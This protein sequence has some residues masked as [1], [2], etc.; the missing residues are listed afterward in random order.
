MR[1]SACNIIC[2]FLASPLFVF[3]ILHEEHTVGV[4]DNPV[5][6]ALPIRESIRGTVP[7]DRLFGRGFYCAQPGYDVLCGRENPNRF[8]IEPNNRVMLWRWKCVLP[9]CH[10]LL[11]PRR[12]GVL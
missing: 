8:F 2:I 10:K 5:K 7:P 1:P 6:P 3:G 11:L 9:C 4:K 12:M